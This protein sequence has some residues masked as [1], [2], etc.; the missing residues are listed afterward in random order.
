M[1]GFNCHGPGNTPGEASSFGLVDLSL[2]FL[3][4]E[5]EFALDA[6][7]FVL[8]LECTDAISISAAT[9]SYPF[10]MLS[11]AKHLGRVFH[12]AGS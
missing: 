10:V 2:F 9:R 7:C 6:V 1:A 12:V 3:R 4:R 8:L 11:E 5:R